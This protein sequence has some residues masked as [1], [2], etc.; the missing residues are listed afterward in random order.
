VAINTGAGFSYTSGAGWVAGW[1]PLVMDVNA[2]G[3]ADLFL[4]NKVTGLWFELEGNG[5][6][7]FTTVGQGAWT[8]GWEISPTD[9]NDDGRADLVLYKPGTGEWF[10]AW[11]FNTGGFTYFGAQWQA[12]LNVIGFAPIKW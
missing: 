3:K 5:A 11:N 10:Q 8:P 2:D 12:G 6:G 4:Y 9:F 1:T 7:Q